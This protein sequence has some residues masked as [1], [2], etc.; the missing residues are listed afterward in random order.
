[1]SL[2]AYIVWP[3]GGEGGLQTNTALDRRRL[4]SLRNG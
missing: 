2:I 1:M 4:L 3:I